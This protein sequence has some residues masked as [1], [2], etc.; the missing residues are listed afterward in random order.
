MDEQ[1][2]SLLVELLSEM[3]K[4]VSEAHSKLAAMEIILQQFQP[5]MVDAYI[6]TLNEIRTNPPFSIA[7]ETFV[8][9]RR[10]LLRG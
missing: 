4:R 9:L 1:T 7:P 6:E 3:T 10:A 5:Q 8:D 2:C